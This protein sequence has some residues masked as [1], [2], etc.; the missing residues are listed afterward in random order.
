[1]KF[2]PSLIHTELRLQLNALN[3]YLDARVVR[4]FTVNP[5]V[6]AK[7][8]S[9]RTD[10]RGSWYDSSLGVLLHARDYCSTTAV[11]KKLGQTCARGL[12]VP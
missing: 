2:K 10:H 6:D 4:L 11:T 8:L 5:D 3:N 7:S 1:M 12:G 9:W